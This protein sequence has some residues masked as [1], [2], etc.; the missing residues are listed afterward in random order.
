ML[1][2]SCMLPVSTVSRVRTP[3]LLPRLCRMVQLHSVWSPKG[4]C[5]AVSGCAIPR[6]V[7]VRSRMLVDSATCR[8]PKVRTIPNPPADALA[9]LHA[10][11]VRGCSSGGEFDAGATRRVF[12]VQPAAVRVRH[13]ARSRL[14]SGPWRR[15]APVI[16]R[17][18]V[19]SIAPHTVCG[20]RRR[21]NL[22]GWMAGAWRCTAARAGAGR[23]AHVSAWLAGIAWAR[24]CVLRG[25]L[26]VFTRVHW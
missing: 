8:N 20:E 10:Y 16:R 23:A 4:G 5:H 25:E 21:S 1:H 24:A 14:S 2:V 18:M 15:R 19:C 17:G 9:P 11:A 7:R 6:R 13:R 3:R 26:L 12:P 22:C